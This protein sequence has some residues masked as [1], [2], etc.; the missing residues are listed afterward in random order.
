MNGIG[1]KKIL[2]LQRKLISVVLDLNSKQ[3]RRY[4]VTVI[5]AK[6]ALQQKKTAIVKQ[7]T[8]DCEKTCRKSLNTF[9]I[10]T[11][12]NGIDDIMFPYKWRAKLAKRGIFIKLSTDLIKALK[13]DC[14]L[15]ASGI[16]EKIF[17]ILGIILSAVE[18]ENCQ[19]KIDI[20]QNLDSI[21]GENKDTIQ[22]NNLRCFKHK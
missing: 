5:P 7:K 22:Q 21:G 14:N 4:T 16:Q 11:Q 3:V 13:P 6:P 17:F 10:D 20:H 19:K 8:Q 15:M 2:Q 18:N 1:I 9:A 12:L